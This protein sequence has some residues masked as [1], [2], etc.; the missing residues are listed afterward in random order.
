M[1]EF[2]AEHSDIQWTVLCGHGHHRGTVNMK[3]NL[4]VHTGAAEYGAPRI[5]RTLSVD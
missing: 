4:I 5:E 3:D 1:L 2:A